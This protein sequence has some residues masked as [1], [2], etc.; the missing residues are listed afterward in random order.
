MPKLWTKRLRDSISH[1]NA[2]YWRTCLSSPYGQC[3]CDGL[4]AI[5]YTLWISEMDWIQNCLSR[6][7]ERRF[8]S[9]FH[10]V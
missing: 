3:S 7:A 6:K 5:A 4:R 10:A 9:R 1:C 2:K 8:V